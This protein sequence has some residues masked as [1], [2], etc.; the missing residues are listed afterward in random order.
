MVLTRH[1]KKEIFS[2]EATATAQICA[3]GEI[4]FSSFKLKLQLRHYFMVHN[5]LIFLH[6]KMWRGQK[7]ALAAPT[8][9]CGGGRGGKCPLCPPV[10]TPMQ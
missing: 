2:V 4:K 7:H 6:A 1:K 10:A 5:V 3:G 9:K 8:S